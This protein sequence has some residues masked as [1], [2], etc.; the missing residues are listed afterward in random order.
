[1]SCKRSVK[2]I[3]RLGNNIALEIMSKY[4]PSK[5]ISIINKSDV[6]PYSDIKAVK[7]HLN[8]VGI[9]CSIIDGRLSLGGM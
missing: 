2:T 3:L 7:E 6:I 9:S 1:M 8:S 5:A 4:P